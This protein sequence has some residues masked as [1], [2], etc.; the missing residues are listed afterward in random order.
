MERTK[1]TPKRRLTNG[2]PLREESVPKKLRLAATNPNNVN[3]VYPFWFSTAPPQINPPFLNPSGPLYEQDGQLA[4]RLVPPLSETNRSVALSYD[5][6]A[7][8]ITSS[9]ALAVKV[10][11]EGPVETSEDGLTVKVDNVTVQVDDDWELAVKTDPEGPIQSNAGGLTINI[12]DTLLVSQDAAT[13]QYELGINLSTSGPLTADENG[14][15]LEYDPESLQLI[16]PTSTA[17]GPLLGVNLKPGGG[18]EKGTDGL[19]VAVTSM[20][21]SSTEPGNTL[22]ATPPLSLASGALTLHVEENS[23][24]VQDSALSVKLKQQGGIQSSTAGLGIA[25]NES[26]TI[27]NNTLE[28]KP[29]PAGPISVSSA[30]V[31]LRT[32]SRTLNVTDSSGGKQLSV[33][34]DPDGCLTSSSNVIKL[35]HGT[36]LSIENNSL[37]IRLKADGGISADENG[38]YLTNNV[39][40]AMALMERSVPT[41]PSAIPKLTSGDPNL[42]S[43]C[44]TVI[45]DQ[46]TKFPCSYFLMQTNC[47]GM[48]STTITLRLRAE[49]LTARNELSKTVSFFTF[50][51]SPCTNSPTPLHAP[52]VTP[53]DYKDNCFT[54]LVAQIGTIS[55][56]TLTLELFGG[57]KH[58]VYGYGFVNENRNPQV[59]CRVATFTLG[60]NGDGA[61]GFLYKLG[62]TSPIFDPAAKGDIIVGP[63][64]YSCFASNAV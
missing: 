19:Y 28:I 4:I 51:V 18:I 46:G 31:N 61:I 48:L 13:Q 24:T 30:G 56:M 15:D 29:D 6:S 42:R 9:G 52:T 32:D 11:P 8:G 27:S 3:L 44:G 26:M 41:Q 60:N 40:P 47:G 2:G 35:N 23:L 33:A 22:S 62:P 1:P 16:P 12:D 58:S 55:P 63:I 43:T 50:W 53:T 25:V 36:A 5:S 54:P 7:L 38:L 59:E 14:L 34:L 20:T 17:S 37:N 10:D 21:L 57:E 39:A 64:S 49:D 45:T